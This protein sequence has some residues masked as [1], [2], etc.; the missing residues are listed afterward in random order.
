MNTLAMPS[1][2]DPVSVMARLCIWLFLPLCAVAYQISAREISTCG[3][4][5]AT[6]GLWLGCVVHTPW[7][8][9]LVVSDIGGFAAWM[10]VLGKMDLSAAFPMTALSYVLVI[11]VSW[12]VFSEPGGI[13]Q[14]LGSAAIM[15]GVFLMGRTGS[16]D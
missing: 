1:R 16:G 9:A 2:T 11:A 15:A 5:V 7:L 4:D 13:A 14:V 3:Q 6:A 12:T 10:F 8:G